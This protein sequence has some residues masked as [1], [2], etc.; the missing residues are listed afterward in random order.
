MDTDTT[1][2]RPELLQVAET[3]ARDKGIEREEVLEAME[4][5]IQ[6][7]GRSKYGQ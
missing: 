5:A 7:A 3:V 1:H 2:V 6:K 4:Q